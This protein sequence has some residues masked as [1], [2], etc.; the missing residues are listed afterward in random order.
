MHEITIPDQRRSRRPAAA[1]GEPEAPRE[2]AGAFRVPE[3]LAPA[4]YFRA[5]LG[6]VLL[7]AAA[8][9]QIVLTGI[10]FVPAPRGGAGDLTQWGESFFIRDR[11]LP[12][13]AAGTALAVLLGLVVVRAWSRRVRRA[14][15]PGRTWVWQ[16]V[17]AAG[18]TALFLG[19]WSAARQP[20]R[21]GGAAPV[22]YLLLFV[23][24]IAGTAAAGLAARPAALREGA[25]PAASP[26]GRRRLSA[27]DI[28]VPALLPAILYVPAWRQLAGRLFLDESLFH[29]D[30]YSMG[31]ALAYANGRALGSEVYSMYGVGWPL[32]FGIL[33]T[34]V[35]LSYGRMI[36][37]GSL[38]A[39]LYL[40]GVYLLLRLVV[41]LPWLAAAGTGLVLLQFFVYMDEVVLWRF[42]SLTVLRWAFDV[43]CF[44]ALV[45]HWRTR[46]SAWAAAAGAAIGLA[47]LF[48]TD[49][50]IYLAFAVALYLLGTLPLAPE[51]RRHLVQSAMLAGVSAAVLVAGLAVAGRGRILQADFWT[52]WL[53]ALLEFG[54]GFAQL[55]MATLPNMVTV[56]AFA[57]LLLAY[58]AVIGYAAARLLHRA[59][60]H[61]DVLCGSIA[62]YGLVNLI[63]FVG[64]SGDYTPFRL[65][66]PLALILVILAGAAIDA[67]GGLRLPAGGRA[68]ALA[69]AGT[70]ALVALVLALPGSVL[71]EP[72]EEYPGLLA[73]A[74]RGSRP[75]GYCLLRNPTDLCGLPERMAASS[76]HFRFVT[77]R[78]REITAAGETFAVVDETGALFYLAT[79]TAS[80]SRYPRIFIAMYTDEK[81][82]EVTEELLDASPDYILTRERTDPPNFDIEDW[83]YVSFGIAPES[84][85]AESWERLGKAVRGSYELAENL[86]PF[87]LWRLKEPV[88]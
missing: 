55:P 26:A 33:D 57:V 35:P 54:G 59:A 76:N 45:L 24:L 12:V 21:D 3:G 68:R 72:L 74:V 56:A 67:R 47:I 7:A 13:F 1:D 32:L 61:R 77:D 46:R 83:P 40:S 53:Q 50:G 16:A 60:A 28:A 23:A 69:A 17:L 82:R 31:P 63:H 64:R 58:L 79:D 11:D 25:A 22:G 85:H 39:C 71:A 48:A 38:Y 5:L 4:A 37:I 84:P 2:A 8:G 10:L 27:F 29:W 41:R 86:S 43:W 15:G 88:R 73:T 81:A 49:T 42:P 52:G 19:L 75:D 18:S 62:V 44:A 51:R 14:A 6:P 80:F 65:W 36:Q 87:E 70:V 78:L 9:V 66:I 20:L 30:F 34:W